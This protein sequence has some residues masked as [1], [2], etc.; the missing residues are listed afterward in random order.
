MAGCQSHADQLSRLIDPLAA[1]AALAG[2]TDTD[3]DTI[4]IPL[5][6]TSTVIIA[7]SL[8]TAWIT[9]T[10]RCNRWS[11]LHHLGVTIRAADIDGGIEAYREPKAMEHRE[12]HIRDETGRV[13]A[14]RRVEADPEDADFRPEPIDPR[15]PGGRMVA[16]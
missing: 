2:V 1:A 7:A 15:R 5:C 6:V 10:G 11:A 4:R 16:L 8:W 9:T 14:T 3:Q 13:V 12:E